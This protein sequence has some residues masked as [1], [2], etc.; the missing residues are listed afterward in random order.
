MNPNSQVNKVLNDVLR[1]DKND[2]LLYQNQED[3]NG[4]YDGPET[5]LHSN[6]EDMIN[7]FFEEMN[8]PE[9]E[10]SI[11]SIL[12]GCALLTSEDIETY[13]FVF[14]T[15]LTAMSNA[16]PTTMLSNQCESIKAEK[17]APVFMK[18]Y[19]WADMMSTQR[20]ES[21]HA[22][23]D[24]YI[25]GQNSLN[26]FIEQYKIALQFKYE[27]ELQ[28]ETESQKK[29]A[30]RCSGFEWDSQLQIRYTRPIYVAFVTEH[31]N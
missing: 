28:E 7:I 11:S 17:R 10:V 5:Y 3:S 6:D 21:M 23:F 27:K 2:S 15:W 1:L 4:A 20:S 13:K 29:H 12:L 26:K 22:F 16:P 9:Q 18:H 25:S 30:W 19:V 24:S 8:Q 31:M 14:S